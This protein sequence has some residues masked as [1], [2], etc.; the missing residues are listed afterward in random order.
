LNVSSKRTA[1]VT[2]ATGFLGLN[3]VEELC[4]SGYDVTALHRPSSDLR[5]LQ[6]FDAR[7]AVGSIT[8]EKTV[9]NAMEEGVDVVFHVAANTGMWARNN[10]VQTRDNVDGTRNMLEVA[11]AKGAKRF[12]YTSSITVYGLEDGTFDDDS[13]L[14]GRDS[15]VNY[16]RTKSLADELVRATAAR[17]LSVVVLRPAHIMG[18]YDRSNWATLVRLVAREKLPGIPPGSGCFCSGREVARAHIRAAERGGDSEA[19]V[20]GGPPAS[21]VELV[22]VIGEVT[23]KRVPRRAVPKA[24]LRLAGHAYA[25]VSAITGKAPRG[26]PEGVAVASQNFRVDD[27]RARRELE[28]AHVPLHETVRESYEF[29]RDESLL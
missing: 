28:Y 1:F 26:T 4:S 7:R 27:S 2:G 8:D 29:L 15:W 17:G 21:F 10:A 22:G 14:L 5:F 23:G 20:L 24:V 19:F 6:R 9:R 12:V 25:A 16:V 11:L 13:P 3:L 18:R